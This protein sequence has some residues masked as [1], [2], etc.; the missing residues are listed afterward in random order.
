MSSI[1]ERELAISGTQ[2][3][4]HAL[5]SSELPSLERADLATLGFRDQH[6]AFVAIQ[7][8]AARVLTCDLRK[9]PDQKLIETRD[10]LNYLSNVFNNVRNFQLPSSGDV[11][12]VRM[13]LINNIDQSWNDA[14]AV[15][16][17]LLSLGSSDETL[18]ANMEAAA[19][20]AVKIR[21]LEGELD[22][23]L[24]TA[25]EKLATGGVSEHAK[26]FENEADY[27]GRIAWGWLGAAVVLAIVAM[28][29]SARYISTAQPS[30]GTLSLDLSHV[31]IVAILTYAIVYTA[32]TSAAARHNQVVNRHRMNALNSFETFVKSASDTQ[33]KNAVLIQATTSIF[34]P[35]DSGFV[36]GEQATYPGTQIV[37]ILKGAAGKE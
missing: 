5:L 24:Q 13:S 19:D 6:D 27:H 14:A 12:S 10:R 26:N 21:G 20:A 36:K 18:K 16:G 37:E 25:R 11:Q 34:A 8:L 4:C 3:A 29:Y 23:I 1:Q 7:D 9:F 28:V 22:S 30:L 32:R 2:S 15:V 17:Q 31:F 35:Q 33:T